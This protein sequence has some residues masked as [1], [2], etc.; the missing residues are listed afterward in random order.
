[1]EARQS[2]RKLIYVPIIHTAVDLGGLA[3]DIAQRTQ[4]IV[5]QSNWQRHIEVVRLYWQAIA[6]YWERK[7]V[8]KIFQDG[9]PANGTMGESIV[10]EVASKGSINYKIVEQL[11]E[12]GAMLIKTES[13]ELL[14][15]EYELQRELA[16]S[17]SL[18][19]SIG[20]LVKYRRRK[21]KLLEAR[22]KYISTRIN[23]SLA[24]GETGVCFLG[25]YHQILPHIAKD[26]AVTTLKDPQ[27]VREYSEKLASS[28]WEEDVNRLG[29]YL[30][31][32]INMTSGENDE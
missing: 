32:P 1:M 22:D 12:K 2:S 21:D 5:G 25:A 10:K 28:K 13:P 30:M 17:Q 24:E 8:A 29:E 6:D 23:L 26:I 15:E 31:A 27:K 3:E 20:A 7:T 18:L 4:A 16:R 11:M 14:R 19:G 9:M